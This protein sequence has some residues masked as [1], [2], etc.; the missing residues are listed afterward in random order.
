MASSFITYADKVGII[1][2]TIRINQV[3]D[4][5]M[6]ELKIVINANANILDTVEQETDVNT[7][8]I[9]DLQDNRAFKDVIVFKSADYTAVINE[10]VLAS[11][12]TVDV[13]I[14][15]PTSIGVTGQQINVS[16]RDNNGF[17]II[18][19]TTSSQTINNDL[20]K[21]ITSQYDNVTLISDGANWII[22]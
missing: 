6:N 22:K 16:K 7:L 20:T 18:V 10:F 17:N 9:A 15:L 2:K 19:N 21:T 1:P 8:D 11:T 12:I 5:D 13:T 14:T 3:W 4:D